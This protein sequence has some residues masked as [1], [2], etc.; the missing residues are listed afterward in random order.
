[1]Y[2]APVRLGCEQETWRVV[3]LYR[4]CILDDMRA[5]ILAALLGLAAATAAFPIGDHKLFVQQAVVSGR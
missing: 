5:S 3:G 2:I 1:M 4:H